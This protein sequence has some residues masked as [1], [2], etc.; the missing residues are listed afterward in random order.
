VFGRPIGMNQGLQFP[1]ADSPARLDAA[2]LTLRQATWLHDQGKPCGREANTAR[3]LC[4]D[5]GFEAADRALQT[6]GGM[7]YSEE[8]DVARHFREARLLKIAPLS[9]EMV[10]I[11]AVAPASPQPGSSPRSTA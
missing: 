4:A 10:L 6:H 5:A 11:S 3:Y 2:E 8:Y 9:Q 1:L 7:G